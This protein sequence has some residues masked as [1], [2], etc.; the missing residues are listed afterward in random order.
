MNV[1]SFISK[2]GWLPSSPGLNP[3]DY[4]IWSILEN[5]VSGTSRLSVEAL[6]RKWT[7]EWAKIPQK[8]IRD[9]CIS[10]SK[11]L[12]QFT[13]ANG[14]E[15]YQIKCLFSYSFVFKYCCFYRDHGILFI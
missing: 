15:A 2:E 11:R 12:Q 6:K 4:G 9:S 5:K 10:L 13:D 8:V 1:S 3:L 14:G 7:T